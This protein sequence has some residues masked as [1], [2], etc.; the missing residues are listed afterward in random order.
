MVSTFPITAII[1]NEFVVSRWEQ[2][3]RID[4][5]DD[6]STIV[7]ILLYT[8][9]QLYIALSRLLSVSLQVYFVENGSVDLLSGVS[10][11]HARPLSRT[12]PQ[13]APPASVH[14]PQSRRSSPR[15][16]RRHS[17]IAGVGGG[18]VWR[19][20]VPDTRVNKV[21]AGAIFGESSFFL[22]KPYRWGSSLTLSI[23]LLGHTINKSILPFFKYVRI[24]YYSSPRDSF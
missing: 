23:P 5:Q 11:T 24:A 15:Y 9:V 19:A 16:D 1:I 18:D 14:G 20:H 22:N 12:Q 7:M 17:A 3:N 21:S 8:Q 4:C 2:Y 6:T 13:A 10:T